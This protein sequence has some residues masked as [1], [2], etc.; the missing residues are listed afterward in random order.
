[1]FWEGIKQIWSSPPVAIIF[2]CLV[3]LVALLFIVVIILWLM[4]IKIHKKKI[5]LAHV[6]TQ[7]LYVFRSEVSENKDTKINALRTTLDKTE[8]GT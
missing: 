4:L 1:M 3:G 5:D 6:K 2:I 7:I 8:K